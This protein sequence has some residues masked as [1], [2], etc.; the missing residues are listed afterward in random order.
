MRYP[1]IVHHGAITGVTGSCHQ[2]QMDDEH[3]PLIDCGL[4]QGAETSSAG[5]A[6][7]GNL[8]PD[9]SLDGIKALVA[10]TAHTD[11]AGPMPGLRAVSCKRPILRTESSVWALLIVLKDAF[12]LGFSRDQKQVERDLK[13]IEPSIVASTQTDQPAIAITGNDICSS[14]RIVNYSKVMRADARHDVLS[15]GCQAKGTSVRQAQCVGSGNGYV[16]FDGQRYD[17]RAQ[18]HTI[19]GYSAHADQA[20]LMR[21]ITGVRKWPNGIRNVHGDD[22]AKAMLALVLRKSYGEEMQTLNVIIPA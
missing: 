1:S 4:F 16:E 6:G 12:K 18:V 5:R 10:V 7:A 19:G 14:G 11:H 15:F 8:A 9:Y 3:A 20:G 2:L 13:L 17:I 22:R 21:F